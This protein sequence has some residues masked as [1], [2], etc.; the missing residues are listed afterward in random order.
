LAVDEE[1]E[2]AQ[3]LL[4]AG[5]VPGLIRHLRAAGE[6]LPLGETARFLAGAAR[7]AGFDDLARAAAAVGSV[8]D[9]F[10][11]QDAQALYDLG[12]ACAERGVPGLAVGPLA[13]ALEL[14]PDSVP[15]LSEFVS[16][17]EQ[18]GQHARVRTVLEE[19]EA[20]MQWEH[21]F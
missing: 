15:A 16:S 2:H 9:G 19:H 4:A 13:L 21:R 6:R 1:L 18:D 11:A 12:Y 7:L 5:D 8:R 17:L 10:R 14:V 20:V 3:G